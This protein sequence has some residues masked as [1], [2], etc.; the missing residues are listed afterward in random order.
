[1]TI[2]PQRK[3]ELKLFIK[4]RNQFLWFSDTSIFLSKLVMIDMKA[5]GEE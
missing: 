4:G 1:M 3:K 5:K 2:L